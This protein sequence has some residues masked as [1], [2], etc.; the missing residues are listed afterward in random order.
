MTISLRHMSAGWLADS[1]IY[2][3]IP[4]PH[5]IAGNLQYIMTLYEL[6]EYPRFFNGHW[7]SPCKPH[8]AGKC[9]PCGLCKELCL[10]KSLLLFSPLSSWEFPITPKCNRLGSCHTTAMTSNGR[11]G[12]SNYRQSNCLFNSHRWSV[13]SPHKEP[14][15]HH[16]STVHCPILIE[17]HWKFSFI[18]IQ[19]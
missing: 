14:Q 1:D 12:V 2:W 3:G 13:D 4:Y 19:I 16:H 11:R 7:L 15:K 10:W 6:W 18:L 8:M 5:W 9:L 17:I